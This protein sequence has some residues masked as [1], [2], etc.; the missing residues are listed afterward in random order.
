M[1]P[2][3]TAIIVYLFQLYD[4]ADER[5]GWTSSF[6]V[7]AC[8]Y[9]FLS[10][11]SARGNMKQVKFRPWG[12]GELKTSGVCSLHKTHSQSGIVCVGLMFI[13]ERTGFYLSSACAC[14]SSLG[15]S[16]ARPCR[17]PAMRAL[18]ILRRTRG[19]AGSDSW[20]LTL[21]RGRW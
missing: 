15:T 1:P 21:L 6:R 7:C 12:R 4:T 9:I 20:F 18:V 19:T 10:H 17:I 13:S 14:V 2:V 5:G 3:R 16:Y 8:L 11:Q